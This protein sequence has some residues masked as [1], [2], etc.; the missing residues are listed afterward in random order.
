MI[1]IAVA[2]TGCSQPDSSEKSGTTATTPVP[3]KNLAELK[4]KLTPM[5]YK[6]AVE[7]GTEPAF[8]NAYW[9]NKKPGIYVDIISGKPLFSSNEKF[10]SGT[11]WPSFYKPLEEEE[12]IEHVDKSWGMTRVEVRSKSGDTHLGHVFE[13]GPDPTGLRYCINSASLRFVPVEDLEK[14]GLGKYTKLFEGKEKA[15]KKQP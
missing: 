2:A 8:K 7:D 14:E 11:G 10:A 5:Q 13:D 3:E 4:E 15:E 6:V 9:D 12:V 1:A